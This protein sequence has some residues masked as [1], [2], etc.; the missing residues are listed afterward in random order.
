MKRGTSSGVRSRIERPCPPYGAG[1]KHQNPPG[2]PRGT[3]SFSI[4]AFAELLGVSNAPAP[5]PLRQVLGVAAPCHAAESRMVGHAPYP[6][7]CRKRVTLESHGAPVTPSA[8]APRVL[9]R[10]LDTHG[11]QAGASGYLGN[12][13]RIRRTGGCRALRHARRRLQQL[14]RDDGAV[15]R[16]RSYGGPLRRDRPPQERAL[17]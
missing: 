8:G 4:G 9:L 16:I 10:T 7:R 17:R 11:A 14:R 1:C 13:H 3:S 6:F 5:R 2:A 12:R 15:R